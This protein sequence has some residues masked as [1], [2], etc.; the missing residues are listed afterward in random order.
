MGR[1]LLGMY[2]AAA[3]GLF[4]GTAAL[5]GELLGREPESVRD[6]LAAPAPEGH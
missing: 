2:E 3:G 5:L 4:A 6:F 1:F